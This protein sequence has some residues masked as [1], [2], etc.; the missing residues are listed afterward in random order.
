MEIEESVEPKRVPPNSGGEGGGGTPLDPP[1]LVDVAHLQKLGPYFWKEC[2]WT[3]W[4]FEQKSPWAR[5]PNLMIWYQKK[6]QRVAYIFK[7]YVSSSL[8]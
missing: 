3:F 2:V 5:T 7:N 8:F 1:I 4:W 6:G